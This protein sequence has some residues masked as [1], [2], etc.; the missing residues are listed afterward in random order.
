MASS[1]LKIFRFNYRAGCD[2]AHI[3]LVAWPANGMRFLHVPFFMAKAQ[4]MLP[5]RS[6]VPSYSNLDSALS[7]H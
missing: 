2:G 6:P 4:S 3:S 1:Q 5:G 7:R